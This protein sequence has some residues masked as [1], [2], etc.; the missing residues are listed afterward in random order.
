MIRA[1]AASMTVA[2]PDGTPGWKDVNGSVNTAGSLT[3]PGSQ[4]S[5]IERKAMP[6]TVLEKRN[7]PMR[8]FVNCHAVNV[9]VESLNLSKSSILGENPPRTI[10]RKVRSVQMVIDLRAAKLSRKSAMKDKTKPRRWRSRRVDEQ[11]PE[12]KHVKPNV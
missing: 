3:R 8:T 9:C 7:V 10:I 1:G 12:L 6:K 4:P 2:A 11:V 5:S